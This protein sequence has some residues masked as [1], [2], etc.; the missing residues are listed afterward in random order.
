MQGWDNVRQGYI[1]RD[2]RTINIIAAPCQSNLRLPWTF[3]MGMLPNPHPHP[4]PNAYRCHRIRERRFMSISVHG[5]C[6]DIMRWLCLAG[7]DHADLG[8]AAIPTRTSQAPRLMPLPSHTIGPSNTCLLSSSRYHSKLPLPSFSVFLYLETA[9]K[10]SV[11][12]SFILQPLHP[13]RQSGLLRSHVPG[14]KA[15]D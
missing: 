12:H 7:H 15:V 4:A 10:R 13:D 14:P 9:G 1:I 5:V 3:E 8:I 11:T 2:L 6:S